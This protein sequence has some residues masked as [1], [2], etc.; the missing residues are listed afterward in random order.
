MKKIAVILFVPLLLFFWILKPILKIRWSKKYFS[1]RVGHMVSE[2]EHYF[3]YRELKKKSTFDIFPKKLFKNKNPSNK[4]LQNHYK[5]KIFT[6][7]DN[8]IKL[9]Q[10]TQNFIEKNFSNIKFENFDK[11]LS[12]RDKYKIFNNTYKP[13]I[14]FSKIDMKQ[15]DKFKSEIELKDSDKLVCLIIRDSKYLKDRYPNLD[16]SYHDY[17]DSDINTFVYGINYL[18]KMGFKVIRMGKNQKKSVKILNKNYFDYSSSNLKT[19]LI[20]VWL[21]SR[22]NLC[23]STGTGL[24]QIARVFNIPTLFINHLPLSDWSSHFKSLTHPKYLIKKKNNE[25]LTLNDQIRYS[26]LR[27]SDYKKNNIRIIDLNKREILNCIREFILLNNNNWALSEKK[28]EKQKDFRRIFKKAIKKY[29]T[30]ID[31]HEYINKHAYI[32]ENFLKKI[33]TSL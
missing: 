30:H 1:D 15:I 20:D 18:I 3:R 29:Q 17:R 2:M 14:R 19:D 22:C 5:K 21:M 12:T 16:L 28:L 32:S 11:E 27:A 24:D 4:F 7:N 8:L 9:F 31:F 6:I 33:K 23:I 26:S 25:L 10:K 13:T